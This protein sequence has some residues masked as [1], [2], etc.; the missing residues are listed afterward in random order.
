MTHQGFQ[1][2]TPCSEPTPLFDEVDWAYQNDAL[3]VGWLP[4]GHPEYVRFHEGARYEVYCFS[5]DW[6]R[7]IVPVVSKEYALALKAEFKAMG[8]TQPVI[9]YRKAGEY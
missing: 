1:M 7:Y 5:P 4:E 9:S 6:V 8:W 2:L 3:Q